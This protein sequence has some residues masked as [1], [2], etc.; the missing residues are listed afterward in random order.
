MVL[1]L[2]IFFFPG[3]IFAGFTQDVVGRRIVAIMDK[4][5]RGLQ[6]GQVYEITAVHTDFHASINST[7]VGIHYDHFGLFQDWYHAYTQNQQV[8]ECLSFVS[9]ITLFISFLR[10]LQTSII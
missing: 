6:E 10:G 8:V 7:G 4:E 2:F 9:G 1:R 5:A 3:V